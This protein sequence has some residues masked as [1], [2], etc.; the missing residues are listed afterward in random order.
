MCQALIFDPFADAG[1]AFNL[2]EIEAGVIGR[3]YT[4]L[5]LALNVRLLH[6]L[7]T[8]DAFQFSL[9]HIIAS[10]LVLI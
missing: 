10:G 4:Q 3:K 2:R 8:I 1:Y 6:L 9:Y 7:F 5:I